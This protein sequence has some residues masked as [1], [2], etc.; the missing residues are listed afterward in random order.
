MLNQIVLLVLLGCAIWFTHVDLFID[1]KKI[2]SVRNT[3]H[4]NFDLFLD[5][6]EENEIPI[7]GLWE[8]AKNEAQEDSRNRE[9]ENEE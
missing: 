5:Y 7:E 4:E 2:I 6:L 9:R 3:H 1:N 8:W